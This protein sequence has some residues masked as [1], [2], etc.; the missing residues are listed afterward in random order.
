MKKTFYTYKMEEGF[1]LEIYCNIENKK[2][3]YNCFLY[4][5]KYFV[6]AHFLTETLDGRS[7]PQFVK[8]ARSKACNYIEQYK[9]DYMI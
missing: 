1:S 8:E 6:K 2:K 5:P 7:F 9:F 3:V 4:H